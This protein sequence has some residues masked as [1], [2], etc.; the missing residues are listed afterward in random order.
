MKTTKLLLSILC[1]FIASSLSATIYTVNAG[2]YYYA[3][4]SLTVNV[5][6]TVEWI[7]DGGMHDVNANIDSQTGLSFNNPVSFQS[8]V[9]NTSGGIIYTHVF[10]VAGTYNY[11][12]SVGSHAAN[13]M[14]G[15]INVNSSN[16]IYDIV[17]NSVNHTTLK[18]AIDAC[19]LDGV[20]SGS[21]PFTLFAPTDA[22]F[23]LLPAGTITAL[24]NDIPALTDILKHHVVADSVMSSM[25]ANNQPVTT[26]LGTDVTVTIS[27]GNV[28]IDNAMVTLADLVADNGVVHVIDAVLIPS[29]PTNSIYDIVSNSPSHTTLKT[30]ID[31]CALDGVLSGSGPFTLFAPTDAAFNLLPAGTVT[32][33][34]NDIPQLTDILKHHVVADSVMSGMLTNNQIVTTLHGTD[35]TV[36]ISGG[37]VYIDNAMVTLADLVA[38]NGVVH[39]IDAVLLPPTNTVYDIVSNSPDHTTLK[40]AIDACSLDGVLSGPGPF[41]LFAPTDAAFNLLPAGTVTAL[42]N[43]IPQLTDILKHHVVGSSVMSTMLSNNQVVTTLNGTDITVT[44]NLMGDVFI[45]NAQVVVADIV[46][47]NGVVHVIDAVLLPSTTSINEGVY[48]IK[49]EFLYTLNLLGE[50]VIN[51]IKNQIVFDIY[52]D[53]SVVKRFVK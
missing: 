45:D 18:T 48:S 41:T 13:G 10:T 25:L 38:D 1:C 14:V 21:G 49:Q 44:I 34:L 51:S 35:V 24:L 22:A 39:V 33:L 46:A 43:D 11:D 9:S 28:Y 27:G 3:P 2:S 5:G 36:T 23:N 8:N 53:G 4:A 20:L 52:S 31:A 47:D 40:A 12:C 30:A 50:K 15:A 32:A 17:S 26:L 7:N 37:N 16:T 29:T 19:A 6:D 42:L